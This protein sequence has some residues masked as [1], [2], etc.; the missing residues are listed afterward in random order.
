MNPILD[1]IAK[2]SI[3][4][5]LNEPF[6]GHFFTAI[7][8]DISKDTESISL[9]PQRLDM[10]KL[11]I[12]EDYWRSV[13]TNP[14]VEKTKNL[15]YGAIKHQI[16]HLVLKHI[17]RMQDFGDKQLFN[18]AADL[19]VNQYIQ[20]DQLSEDAITL[21]TFPD[22]NMETQQTL[23]YY[24]KRL[25]EEAEEIDK[26]GD[27]A[28]EN[29]EEKEQENQNNANNNSDDD[30]EDE[31]DNEQKDE[32][33]QKYNPNLNQ[34]QNNLLNLSQD[35]NN[36]HTQQHK[37][38]EKIAKMS[39]AERKIMDAMINE[40]IMTTMQRTRN[41]Q[42]G[43]LPGDL[44]SYLDKLLETL[45]P[46]VNWRRVLRL[47][48]ATSSKTYI[49]STIQKISKRYGVS[50]G[51]K[52]KHRQKLLVAIDTSG[53]VADEELTEFFAEI[54]HIWRN[55]ASIRIIECDAEIGNNYDYN[56]KQPQTVSG[57]GGTDF[58]PPIY[59]ANDEYK[60][61]GIVYFTDGQA[62]APDIA[63]RAPILWLISSGGI[64]AEN[65]DFLPGRKVKMYKQ[66]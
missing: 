38:W 62:P 34:S 65:W 25:K 63:A 5:M 47:F 3:Q 1:E 36:L 26:A 27:D 37:N 28:A 24:Y 64:D 29:E 4:M 30:N 7:V 33:K 22:F 11:I 31:Q 60:P 41:K 18:M 58:N 55:G 45:K 2:T 19:S 50:P 61:N 10:L 32:K 40:A 21:E 56:G 48:A 35:K 54:Y 46:N 53:S 23:D 43:T 15:R 39:T 52:I 14:S 44:Q 42:R 51:I 59:Y 49:K 12:N 20:K 16:L 13:L 17:L 57:R 6:F 66:I 9:E 8:K